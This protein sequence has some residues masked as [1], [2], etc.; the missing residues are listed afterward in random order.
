MTT[1]FESI[2]LLR[3]I[4]RTSAVAG[5]LRN[6]AIST[7]IAKPRGGGPGDRRRDGTNRAVVHLGKPIERLRRLEEP[8]L[9]A[10]RRRLC[11]GRGDRL[12]SGDELGQ[13]A[14]VLGDGG[15]VE[16]VARAENSW[17]F[18]APDGIPGFGPLA[19]DD[20][21]CAPARVAEE[22]DHN[23]ETAPRATA[24]QNA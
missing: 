16:L 21:H 12:R 14:Q 13:L 17:H 22:A 19:P 6:L 24:W 3:R 7:R 9:T 8:P 23:G 10:E 11:L 2:S 5:N 18:N 4:G 20:A 1:P 15:E